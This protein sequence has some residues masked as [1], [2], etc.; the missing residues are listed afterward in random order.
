MRVVHSRIWIFLVPLGLFFLP[1]T[2]LMAP[3]AQWPTPVFVAGTALLV[4]GVVAFFVSLVL[5]RNP[6]HRDPVAHFCGTMAGVIWVVFSWSLL[7]YLAHL[8]LIL[9]GV[10]N[11]TRSRIIAVAV[12]V[13]VV[14]LLAWGYREATRQPR[15]KAL[16]VGVSGLGKGLDGL[17]IVMIADT[18]FGPMDRAEWSKQVVAAVNELNPDV[19]CHVGD[20]AD[21]PVARRRGQVAPLQK[22]EAP[23][24]R[25]YVTGDH[26]YLTEAQGWLDYMHGLG[27]NSLHNQHVVVERGES[28]LVFAGVD[29]R[30]GAVLAGHGPDL[31]AALAGADSELPVVLLAHQP[32]QVRQAVE[33]GVDLQLSGHTHG[34]QI[35]PFRYLV[36]LDQPV[37]AGLSR[38][39]ERTQ[40]YTSRGTGFWGPPLRIFAPSEITLLTLRSEK[41][42]D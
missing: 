42:D 34:G 39:G 20:L 1:W 31:G 5:V 27:W 17:R 41:L 36:R 40:L 2:V 4:A 22:I 21:G 26:E 11:P 6:G 7:G 37:V 23:Y 15:V 12:L 38:H 32:K 30:R 9:I 13:I 25:F 14:V 8:G 10:G 3:A 29:D 33:A 24:G 16:D 18:H 19:V 28:R 35:W